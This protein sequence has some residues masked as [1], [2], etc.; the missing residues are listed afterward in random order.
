MFNSF[1]HK[2]IFAPSV[3]VCNAY[4]LTLLRKYACELEIF[5][6]QN[7]IS[8]VV[9]D[10]MLADKFSDTWP[11]YCRLHEVRSPGFKTNRELPDR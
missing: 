6:N 9:A 5:T 3:R 8:F 4:H 11:E 1:W 2:F 10:A 7:A